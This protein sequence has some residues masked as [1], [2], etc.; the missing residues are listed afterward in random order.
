MTN[1]YCYEIHKNQLINGYRV[2]DENFKLVKFNELGILA[3]FDP[4]VGATGHPWTWSNL[5]I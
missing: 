1:T 3:F 2:S 5:D 4:G